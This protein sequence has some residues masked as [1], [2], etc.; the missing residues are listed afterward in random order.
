MLAP[1]K[2]APFAL[3]FDVCLTTCGIGTVTV[4]EGVGALENDLVFS[5][6]LGSFGADQTFFINADAASFTFQLQPGIQGVSV[7]DIS[8]NGPHTWTPVYN[9]TNSGSLPG[10]WTAGLTY[11]AN[12]GGIGNHADVNGSTLSFVVSADTAL[13][14]ASL[15]RGIEPNLWGIWFTADVTFLGEAGRIG[16]CAP[17]GTG[18]CAAPPAPTPL[19]TSLPLFATILGVLGFAVSRPMRDHCHQA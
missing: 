3:M 9:P 18:G 2:A 4:T 1:A 11:D 8:G 19:P 15:A 14:I 13:T 6:D 5:V 17:L 10:P 7:F 16:A 12:P